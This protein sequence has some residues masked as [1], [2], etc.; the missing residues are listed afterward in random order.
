[1]SRLVVLCS[2]QGR[3][4]GR[5]ANL[6]LPSALPDGIPDLGQAH[7]LDFI[8]LYCSI[9]SMRCIKV[10]DVRGVEPLSETHQI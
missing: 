8:R 4:Q 2:H 1:M 6:P 7:A 3:L 9:F 5:L 10:V